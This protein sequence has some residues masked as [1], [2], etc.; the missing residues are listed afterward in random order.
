MSKQMIRK[1]SSIALGSVAIFFIATAPLGCC[2]TK[3]C[4]SGCSKKKGCA[5]GCSKP[6]CK[7]ASAKG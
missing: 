3:G 5:A 6:C 1:I 7:K 2:A 4:S